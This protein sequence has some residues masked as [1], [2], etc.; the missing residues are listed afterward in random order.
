[1][2]RCRELGIIG[3]GFVG[4]AIKEVLDSYFVIETYDKYLK[5]ASTCGTLEEISKKSEFLFLC[6]PTPMK[7][8]GSCDLS[9]IEGVISELNDFKNN[10]VVIIKSTVVPGTCSGLNKKHKNLDIVFNPEFLTER[11]AVQDFRNQNRIILGGEK[12]VTGLVR[13]MYRIPFQKV[14][15]VETNFETA[16]MAKYFTNNYLTVKVLF[17]NEMYKICERIGVNYDEVMRY[18]LWDGRIEGSHFDV[19]GHDGHFGVGGSCF[20]KDLNAMIHFCKNELGCDLHILSAAWKTNLEVR[21][22]R[23]WEELRGRAV[24]HKRERD[25]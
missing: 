2:N 13:R 16:E 18:S 1:M 6:L 24:S 21:P 4:S 23:D 22:E 15:I 14:T 3:Q 8:D 5:D 12:R 19:P 10:N 25:C 17:A 20:P 7:E 11:F 9:I